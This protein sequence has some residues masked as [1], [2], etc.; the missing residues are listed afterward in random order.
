MK[1]CKQLSLWHVRMYNNRLVH[2]VQMPM[3]LF[4]CFLSVLAMP[5]VFVVLRIC[6]LGTTINEPIVGWRKAFIRPFMM[7][8]AH[9]LLHIGFNIWPSLAGL[10]YCSSL[11]S[12]GHACRIGAASSLSHN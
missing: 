11:P 4:R 12:F 3:F 2:G 1:T 5:F 7:Y 8:W 9:V 10:D 6:L